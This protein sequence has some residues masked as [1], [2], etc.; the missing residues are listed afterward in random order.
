M[1]DP[2]LDAVAE[3]RAA[4]EID[5]DLAE[6]HANLGYALAQIP[7]RHPEA[8]ST[9]HADHRRGATGDTVLHRVRSMEPLGL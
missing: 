9:P 8:G 1:P 7:S 2:L 3:Y 4:L 5:P 6:V